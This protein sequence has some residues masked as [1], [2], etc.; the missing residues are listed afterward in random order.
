[1]PSIESV[2]RASQARTH[3]FPLLQTATKTPRSSPPTTPAPS[4]T[5]TD[6]PGP[7]PAASGRRPAT[8]GRCAA[9][10][11]S[12]PEALGLPHAGQGLLKVFVELGAVAVLVTGDH[13]V[14][15]V[16][17][18]L[19]PRRPSQGI[20]RLLRRARRAFSRHLR[21][22]CFVLRLLSL[23]VMPL[24]GKEHARAEH[25]NL[26]GDEDYRDPIHL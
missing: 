2:F 4:P 6:T 17:R 26:E 10:S 9:W 22:A 3:T 8:R 16:G 5:R 21:S 18:S 1:M 12:P 25:E 7:C 24:D 15:Q 19:M 14:I 11:S 23:V 13:G 20:S